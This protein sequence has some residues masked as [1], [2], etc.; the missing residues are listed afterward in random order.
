MKRQPKGSRLQMYRMERGG[1]A[2]GQEW[3]TKALHG[4]SG[5]MTCP[6]L[7]VDRGERAGQDKPEEEVL[8]SSA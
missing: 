5:R 7:W 6:E 4:V 2:S 3:E 8:E 1:S